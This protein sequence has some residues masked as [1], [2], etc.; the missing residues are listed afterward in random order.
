MNL[1]K[2]R[3][4][5]DPTKIRGTINLIGCGSVGSNLGE[6]L[7]RMGCEKFR[8]FDFDVVEAKNL[9]NQN[10][11]AE[12]I[13][14]AKVEALAEIIH[15]INPDAMVEI[16]DEG[17]QDQRLRGNIFLAVD[18]IELRRKIVEAN[19]FNNNI[20]CIIDIRTRLREAQMYAADKDRE[21]DIENLLKTMDFSHEEAKAETEVSACGEILGV[22]T[23]VKM[24]CAVACENFRNYIE[25]YE[26]FKRFAVTNI[27][28]ES[29]AM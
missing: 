18:N 20:G 24:I 12:Q 7:A 11:T 23:T 29:Y 17:Y 2:S 27:D 8:L 4:F 6:M 14:R 13:G 3:E 16:E 21:G 28:G 1:A 25:E 5:F 26:N 22:C 10:F 15:A 19:K 9:A